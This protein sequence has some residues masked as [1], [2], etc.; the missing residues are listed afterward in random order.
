MSYIIVRIFKFIFTLINLMAIISGIN[1]TVAMIKIYLCT[2][3]Y[4]HQ[5]NDGV[6]VYSFFY[7]AYTVIQ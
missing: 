2:V 3:N 5:I 4:G 7:D 1:V 6:I